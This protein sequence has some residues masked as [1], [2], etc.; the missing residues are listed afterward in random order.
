MIGTLPSPVRR[1]DR[2]YQESEELRATSNDAKLFGRNLNW[3]AGLYFENSRQVR[4]DNE[5]A[6]GLGADFE[7]IYGFSID[8]SAIGN[9]TLPGVFYGNDLVYRDNQSLDQVQ[10]AAFTQADYEILPDLK[11]TAGVRYSYATQNYYRNSG[12][13][14]AFGNVNPFTAQDSSYSLTPKFSLTYD[15]DPNSTLYSTVAKG[16]R[17]GGPTGPVASSNCHNDL[18]AIGIN[19]PP[20]SYGPDKLWSYEA[21]AKE[22]LLDNRLSVD[23]D[24]YYIDWSN[25]QQSINLPTCGASITQNLGAAESYGTEFQLHAKVLPGLTLGVVG[26]IT[27][28]IITDSPNTLTAAPGEDVLNTPKWTGTFSADYEWPLTN[29]IDAF[30]RADLDVVGSS[31][32]AFNDTDP[33][34]NQPRYTVLNGSLGFTVDSYVVT[35]YAKNLGDNN[36]IIQRP[37]INF[38]EE[39]YTLRPLTIGMTASMKF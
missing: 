22:L 18:A 37:S 38:V 32:G 33:A 21:G 9:A 8:N 29:A 30:A 15:L 39:A 10:Y 5:N 19:T 14:L 3:I 36:K 16:Y 20:T 12:G 7:K 31:H 11:A 24:V 4:D 1:T 27:R 25:I 35:L 26:G 28:A 23:A 34:F 2:D 6:P 13:V 17:L